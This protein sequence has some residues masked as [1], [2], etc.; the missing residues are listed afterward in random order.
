MPLNKF[1]PW[2]IFTITLTLLCSI[3]FAQTGTN[4]LLTKWQKAQ[5][6]KNYRT[7]TAN[8][9]LL[10]DLAGEYLYKRT[11]SAIYY[12]KEALRLAEFQKNDLGK[13][14]SM[15]SLC[16]IYYVMGDYI[17]SLDNASKLM[18]ISTKI[19]YQPGIAGSYLITGLIYIF[20]NKYDIALN[21][22]KKALDIFIRLKENERIAKAYFNIGLCYDEMGQYENSFS[23]L[24]KSIEISK[25]IGDSNGISMALNRTGEI[26]FHLKNYKSALTNYQQVIDSKQSSNWEVDFAYSGLAQAY[27]KLG[28][29]DKAILNAK[30]S[31]DLSQKVN[32]LGDKTR[33]LKILSE[34]YAAVKDYKQAYNYETLY[35]RADDSLFN[36]EKKQQVNN[37]HLKQQQADNN[38]LINEIRVK[39]QSIAFSKR[40]LFFRN[41]IAACVIVFF[42]IIIWSNRQKT[43]LNKLLQQQK[44]EI[45]HQ[46]EEL[47]QL[48]YTKDQLFSVI[49]HDLRSPFAAILQTMD[50][51]RSGDLTREEQKAILDGF[52]QQVNLVTIMMNNL[53]VWANSQQSG[54]K[55]EPVKLNVT[56]TVNE[57]ISI[58]NFLAKN[59]C[60]SINH[61]Y[62]GAKWVFADLNHLKIIFQNIIGNAIKFT[63]NGGTIEIYYTADENYQ[64]IRIKDNGIGILPQKMDKL[65]NVTGKEISGYGTNNEAGA[66]IG[67]AL[68]KQFAD[69]NNGKIEVQSQP[70]NGSE[71]TVYLKIA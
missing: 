32:S 26:Y 1:L 39:E 40:L 21:D 35:K 57:I 4:G 3:A 64:A 6:E 46:K 29:Y 51:I 54:I 48:N 56:E 10:N 44:E 2:Y 47:H 22:L 31:L 8:V 11:D 66:G 19:N 69:A 28:E 70:G 53:L 9:R 12:A 71:F 38:R 60:I 67:L 55:A 24:K 68:I 37:L 16:R 23:Y 36:S 18:A 63:P 59:K 52:Y 27:Y 14:L 42:I 20:E 13:A 50:S 43:A 45:S 41:M 5:S 30:K 7:D 58:S 65:F 34:S 49:S 15:L 61:N 62:E 33:A 17:S 25:A